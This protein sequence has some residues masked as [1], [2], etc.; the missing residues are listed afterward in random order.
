MALRAQQPLL[1]CLSDVVSRRGILDDVPY[2]HPCAGDRL[3]IIVEKPGRRL[4]PVRAPREQGV[5]RFRR[6]ILERIPRIVAE[7]S[8]RDL[9]G[10]PGEVPP[11][12]LLEVGAAPK[13]IQPKQPLSKRFERNHHSFVKH[14]MLEPRRSRNFKG[15][16]HFMCRT[17]FR[18]FR[19][20]SIQT[21]VY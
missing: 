10:G 1:Q 7:S 2:T 14:G 21:G 16:M 4:R 11:T 13:C 3:V 6:I 19:K 5:E 15:R 20:N 18:G 12:N 8:E 9:P 17:K